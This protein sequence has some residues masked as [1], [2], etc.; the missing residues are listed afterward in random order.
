MALYSVI[1]NIESYKD[2]IIYILTICAINALYTHHKCAVYSLFMRI[3][4][5]K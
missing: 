1:Y 3:F 4:T 5:Y 2:V